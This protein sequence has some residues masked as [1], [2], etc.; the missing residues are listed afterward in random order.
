[1]IFYVLAEVLVVTLMVGTWY[2][3]YQS[4]GLRLSIF[5]LLA[6]VSVTTLVVGTLSG[7]HKMFGDD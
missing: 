5:Y 2:L 1:M 7:L 4:T 3:L 6:A